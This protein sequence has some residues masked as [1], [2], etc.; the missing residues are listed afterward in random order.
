MEAP[1]VKVVKV[2]Q[3]AEMVGKAGMA[4]RVEKAATRTIRTST[5]GMAEA[6]AVVET[7]GTPR[8]APAEMLEMVV[9]AAMVVIAAEAETAEKEAMAATV[10]TAEIPTEP[11]EAV[12]A[13]AEEGTD[14]LTVTPAAPVVSATPEIP[15]NS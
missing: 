8:M 3:T 13:P 9:K 15:L 11:A 2:D 7:A 14:R 12:A 6:A 1:V 4:V 10:A 5:Q